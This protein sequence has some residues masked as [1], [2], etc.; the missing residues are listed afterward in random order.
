MRDLRV[1]EVADFMEAHE[2]APEPPELYFCPGGDCPGLPYYQRHPVSCNL[3]NEIPPESPEDRSGE[4][5][6]TCTAGE[7]SAVETA[8]YDEI[9]RIGATRRNET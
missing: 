6:Y 7:V 3:G 8:A 1:L 9:L 5:I 4:P 2:P